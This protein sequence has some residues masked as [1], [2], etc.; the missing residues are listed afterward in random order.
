MELD[1][2]RAMRDVLDVL[3][4]AIGAAECGYVPN[5]KVQ[6]AARERS[7]VV[8]KLLAVAHAPRDPRSLATT[9]DWHDSACS[10]LE[11]TGFDGEPLVIPCDCAV[12]DR[13]RAAFLAG[14]RS[15]K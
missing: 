14:Q 2:E 11:T 8:R 3:D 1:V 12:P 13:I 6:K 4:E 15:V 10:F 5:S 7:R 9:Y